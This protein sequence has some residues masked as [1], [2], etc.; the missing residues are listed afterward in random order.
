MKKQILLFV[1][2]IFISANFTAAQTRT[3]T[4]ADLEKFRQK[5]V[6]AERDYR[7]SYERLGLP[8]PEELDKRREQ[9][10]KELT[11]LS[12][13]LQSENLEREQRRREDDYRQMQNQYLRGV[14]QY[15]QGANYGN[16]Y[17]SGYYGSFPYYG[18]GLSFYSP[19]PY[20]GYT[21]GYNNLY[22]N[23]FGSRRNFKGGRVYYNP[24]SIFQAQGFGAGRSGIRIGVG[25][26][27]RSSVSIR[28]PR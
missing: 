25:S 22:N 4:N 15:N 8:S 6:Q 9:N 24:L 12:A 20:Y 26:G 2:F 27:S 13:R 7:D 19:S 5:R 21:N 16:G 28:S 10:R 1:G 17:S 11:E 3:V 23:R 14:N 18:F